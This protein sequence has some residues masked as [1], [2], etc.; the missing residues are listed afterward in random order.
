MIKEEQGALWLALVVGIVGFSNSA[1]A[2]WQGTV[3]GMSVEEADKSF[4]IP[5][6]KP[7]PWEGDSEKLEF[8][9]YT[10]GNIAFDRG[11]LA[12]EHN[13]LVAWGMSLKNTG[14]CD[15]LFETYRSIYGS[16]VSDDKDRSGRIAIWHD[17]SHNNQIYLQATYEHDELLTCNLI[18][19]PLNPLPVKLTPAPGG[20]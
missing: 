15:G 11:Y 17:A 1:C 2:D 13:R 5:H 20:L 9:E 16:P 6:K 19:M 3:W 7:V 4:R 10:T 18:Y 8:D 14:Q 12:F